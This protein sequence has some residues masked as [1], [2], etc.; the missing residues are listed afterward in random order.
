MA[1]IRD[2]QRLPWIVCNKCN[3]PMRPGKSCRCGAVRTEVDE[4]GVVH[5][6]E[7]GDSAIID[8][9]Q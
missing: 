6:D 3:T 1:Q 5:I 8:T 2:G 4:L 7:D 9:E